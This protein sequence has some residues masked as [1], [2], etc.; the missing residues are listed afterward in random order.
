MVF[1]LG[2]FVVLFEA[3]LLEQGLRRIGIELGERKQLLERFDYVHWV[4]FLGFGQHFVGAHESR[5]FACVV[6]P[7]RVDK[8]EVK[9]QGCFTRI[10]G[11][12][13]H[14]VVKALL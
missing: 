9:L 8:A 13:A 4:G 7:S 14:D 3:L 5:D 6:V 2:Y 10:G 11:C 12:L 1:Y